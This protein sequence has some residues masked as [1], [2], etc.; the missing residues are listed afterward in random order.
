MYIPETKLAIGQTFQLLYCLTGS[1][2]N[3]NATQFL[4]TSIKVKHLIIIIQ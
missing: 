1:G 2:K 4:N 3:R